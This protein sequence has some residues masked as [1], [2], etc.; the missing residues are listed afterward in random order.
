M[1]RNLPWVGS[2]RASLVLATALTA[3]PGN[4]RSVVDRFTTWADLVDEVETG[5]TDRQ[6][7]G[8]ATTQRTRS[9]TFA[10][11][12]VAT[13]NGIDQVGA[14]QESSVSTFQVRIP[15]SAPIFRSKELPSRKVCG[16][17]DRSPSGRRSISGRWNWP[18]KRRR[19][20]RR[21]CR[22]DRRRSRCRH[23]SK[24]Q[25]SDPTARAAQRLRRL[26]YS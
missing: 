11:V 21:C 5:C 23:H 1:G 26:G 13:V 22:G 14:T 9:L 10:K 12:R 8:L 17:G 24:G 4:S 2:D 15:S 7:R 19:R 18:P 25:Q 16:D 20:G 3:C 6:A